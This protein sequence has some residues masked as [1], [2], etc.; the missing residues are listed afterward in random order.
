MHPD[1]DNT[2]ATAFALID[3][4][5]ADRLHQLE[6]F[7]R[8][9]VEG[10]LHGPNASP[11]RGFSNDFLQHRQY[12]PGDN[13]KYLD[14]RV[15]GRSERLMLRQYEELT[16]APIR[17]VLDCSGS[18][19]HRGESM[20]KW[21]FALR[22][23]AI[24]LYVAYLHRDSFSLNTFGVDRRVAVPLGTGKGHL[25]RCFRSLLEQGA[26]GETDFAQ[27]MGRALATHSRRGLTVVLSDF[28]DD[29]MAI[30]KRLSHLRFQKSDIIAIQIID[31]TEKDLDFN[32]VTRFHDLENTGILAVDPQLIRRAYRETFAAHTLALK[33]ACQRHG[34]QHVSL[35]VEDSFEVPILEYLRWRLE[36]AS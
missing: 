20:T 12:F 17:V 22:N 35:E 30:A 15:Y 14:W 26:D 31:P 21:D 16:N 7:S 8:L 29:P 18:M 5:L 25:L 9:R 2:P 11:F 23:A 27:G 24:L 1:A 13:L 28:M 36:V 4:S 10:A 33:D 6:L 19:L 3:G 32:S 34:F